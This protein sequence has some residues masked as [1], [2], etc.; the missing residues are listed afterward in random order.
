[1]NSYY[2]GSILWKGIIFV[3]LFIG[4]FLFF[5]KIRWLKCLADFWERTKS[6]M[7]E[8][9][10][11][12]LR[13]RRKNLREMTNKFSCFRYV[14]LLLEYSGVKRLLPGLD[15]EK[16]LAF[17]IVVFAILFLTGSFFGGMKSA[18]LFVLILG[19]SEVVCLQYGRM[20]ALKS[21]DDNLLKFLDFLGNYSITSGE[22]TAIFHQIS[23]YMEEPLKGALEECCYEAETTGDVG[24]ALLSMAEKIEHPKFK[25]FVRNMEINLR[26]CADFTVLVSSGRKSVRDYQKMKEER[27]SLLREGAINLFLLLGMSVVVLITVGSLV[28]VSVWNVLLF[29]VPGRIG[30]AVIIGIVLL[31]AGQILTMDK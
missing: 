9:S 2:E 14:E 29:S 30:L 12:R 27:K 21:V 13:E 6:D 17:Q 11:S 18:L 4:F 10:R 3:A 31:F 26:Y 5:Q 19:L 24:L 22:I 16:F 15:M 8:S 1:M 25:E 7:E 20:K 28:E 23:K